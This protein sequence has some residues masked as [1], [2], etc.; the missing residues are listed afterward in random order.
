MTSADALTITRKTDSDQYRLMA[1]AAIK[2][3]SAFPD[4]REDLARVGEDDQEAKK[5]L[6]AKLKQVCCTL[7]HPIHAHT[8]WRW[9]IYQSFQ[10]YS[11]IPP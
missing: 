1:N 11:Q 2:T 4:I 6:I 3:M 9:R 8:P 10:D 5:S 7:P